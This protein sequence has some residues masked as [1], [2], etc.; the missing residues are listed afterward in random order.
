MPWPPSTAV[1]VDSPR[2]V[3]IGLRLS[4]HTEASGVKR[5]PENISLGPSR[6]GKILVWM[7][8]W[9]AVIGNSADGERTL[10]IPLRESRQGG[11]FEV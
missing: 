4:R 3:R 1:A 5:V 10:A 9:E 7:W 6:A 11:V 2:L 8:P